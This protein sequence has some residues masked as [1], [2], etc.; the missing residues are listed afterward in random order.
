MDK[1]L[2][3]H[4]ND[5]FYDYVLHY[6]C[7]KKDISDNINSFTYVSES[8]LRPYEYVPRYRREELN[9]EKKIK[10]CAFEDTDFTF[11]FEDKN[12]HLNLETYMNNGLPMKINMITE[13]C[14][15]TNEEVIFKKLTLES[16][17][18]DILIDFVDVAKAFCENQMK[19]CKKSSNK[20]VKVYYWRK[21][22][23]NLLFKSPKRPI[24]TLYL[25]EKQKEKLLGKVEEFYSEETRSEYL[26]FGIPYKCI[27]LLYGIPGS[28]KTSAINTIASHFDCDI[29]TIPISKELTD[30]MLIDAI[31]NC[32]EKEDRKR[33][34]VIED[35]DTIFTNRKNGDDHN[36]VT[37][38][39]LLNCFDGFSCAEGTL[40]FITANSP[41]VFDDALLRS[42]RIDYRF[43]FDYADEYQTK[44]I[45]EMVLPEQKD[46]FN[47]F[48]KQIRTKKYTTAMLQEFLFFNRKCEN[49]LEK[50]SEFSDIIEKNDP[51]NFEKKEKDN[52][53]L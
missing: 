20:T 48:Y 51:K 25:K 53:Y 18:K 35:I 33:I 13:N 44:N 1:K 2:V 38:Q 17:T 36:G 4:T 31:A 26:S 24:E 16:E 27:I 30:Y 49:I 47:K 19:E 32:E 6:I 45:F 34:I 8:N 9:K 43:E 28:G 22:Y 14:C 7:S 40:L 42:C 50:M 11:E 3:L 52:I 10:I 41:E 15:G 29:Y 39:G 5:E 46:K 12:I 21:D 23:W 37:L